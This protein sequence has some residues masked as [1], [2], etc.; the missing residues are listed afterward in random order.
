MKGTTSMKPKEYPIMGLIKD[1]K[2]RLEEMSVS[3]YF[4]EGVRRSGETVSKEG[5]DSIK[6]A[7]AI[8][9]EALVL[10]EK[11]L[12]P[13]QEPFKHYFFNTDLPTVFPVQLNHIILEEI[14]LGNWIL[15]YWTGYGHGVLFAKPFKISRKDVNP[16]LKYNATNDPH[17]W[18]EEVRMVDTE[19]F[20]A[21]AFDNR[22]V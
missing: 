3:H 18:K 17:Y 10:D 13:Q 21:A 14:L 6:L 1:W 20:V 9:K 4:M 12:N 11:Y 19:Y 22:A 8:A 16:P 7:E 5:S 15:D 2:F